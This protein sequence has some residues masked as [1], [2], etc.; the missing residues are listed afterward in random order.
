MGDD[1]KKTIATDSKIDIA[2]GIFS[3]YGYAVL[4]KQLDKIKKLR[5]IFTD[6]TFIELDKNNREERQF[7]IN[8]NHR[9]KA[10]K[11]RK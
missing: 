11:R 10:I 7:Q 8:S 4:K 2:A 5:F 9:K 1:F 6:P 3:I